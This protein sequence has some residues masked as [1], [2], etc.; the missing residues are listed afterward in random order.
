MEQKA[1][2]GC[3]DQGS[4]CQVQGKAVEVHSLWTGPLVVFV[5]EHSLKENVPWMS[6]ACAVIWSSATVR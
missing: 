2:A 1:P 6:A 4:V 5:T 3:L